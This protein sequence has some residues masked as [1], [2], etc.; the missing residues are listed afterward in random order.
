MAAIRVD[1]CITRAEAMLASGL[2]PDRA[3]ILEGL[4]LAGVPERRL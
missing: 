1:F 4:R 3:L 2:A